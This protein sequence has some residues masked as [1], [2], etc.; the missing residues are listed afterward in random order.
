MS[1]NARKAKSTGRPTIYSATLRDQICSA[2]ACGSNLNRISQQAGMPTRETLYC[3]L[4]DKPDF[5]DKY[6]RAREERADWRSDRI[7]DIVGKMIDGEIDA[8][9]ARVAIDAEKWQA[10]KEKP[11]RYGDKLELSGDRENPLS[12]VIEA[13]KSLDAKLERLIGRRIGEDKG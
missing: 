7:D 11:K 9:V 2:V 5:A 12:L 10:G 13:G 1:K 8:N 3:W 4:R 6:G